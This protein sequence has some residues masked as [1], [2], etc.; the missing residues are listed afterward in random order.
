MVQCF[1]TVKAKED[2]YKGSSQCDMNVFEGKVYTKSP[3]IPKSMQR[4]I[5]L[6]MSILD[7]FSA[8]KAMILLEI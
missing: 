6:K 1:Q 5:P 4:E 2:S 3:R 8:T 7:D